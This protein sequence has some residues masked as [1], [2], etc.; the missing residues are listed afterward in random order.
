MFKLN[1]S[2]DSCVVIGWGLAMFRY[3]PTKVHICPCAVAL[4]SSTDVFYMRSVKLV[5]LRGYEET[6]RAWR[7]I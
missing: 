4:G 6:H 2:T 5:M 1:P 3:I 7:Y